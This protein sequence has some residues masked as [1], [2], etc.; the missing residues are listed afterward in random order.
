M[1]HNVGNNRDCDVGVDHRNNTSCATSS[2]FPV[3]SV[4]LST[5]HEI[6]MYVAVCYMLANHHN[7][8]ILD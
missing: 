5:M 2:E 3:I 6:Y 8:W 7:R 4:N 1:L